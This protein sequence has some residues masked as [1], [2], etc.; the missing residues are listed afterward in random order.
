MVNVKENLAGRKFGKLKVIE[1]VEDAVSSSGRHY[2]QWLCE[3]DCGNQNVIVYGK[4]LKNEHTQSCGCLSR[5]KSAERCKNGTKENYIDDSGDFAI[6]YTTKG[7]EFWFDKDLIPEVKKNCWSY[8]KYGYV[9]CR[10]RETGKKIKLHRMAMNF[11]DPKYDVNHK[12]HPPR[13]EHKVDNRR[14]NLEV[15]THSENMM[16]Q[17]K[18]TKNTS[19]V[20]GVNWVERVNKWMAKIQVNKKQIYLGYFDNIEDAAKARADAELKYFGEHRLEANN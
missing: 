8:D 2:D 11:P 9:Y 20:K 16:N 17:H 15:V 18:N 6:G 12:R 4:S 19:G 10:D 5:E 3:C 1:Q 7:E 13:N 14:E